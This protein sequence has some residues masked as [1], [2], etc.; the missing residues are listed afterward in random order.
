MLADWLLLVQGDWLRTVGSSAAGRP[1]PSLQ[2]VVPAADE[3][4]ASL[5]G[6]GGGNAMPLR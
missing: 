2:L 4:R 1:A 6:W 5:E 3:I